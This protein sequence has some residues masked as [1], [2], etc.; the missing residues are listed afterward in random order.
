MGPA[1]E[2]AVIPYLD[3]KYA[4]TTR[5]WAFT[6]VKEIGGAASIPAL[7]AVQGPDTL[8]V[9]DVLHACR[10]RVPLGKEEWAR[11]LEDL[12][13]ADAKVRASAT[14]RI[15]VTPPVPERRAE[16]VG[17]LETLVN[18]Q[19]ADVRAAAFKGLVRW[20]GKDAVTLLARASTV[21]TPLARSPSS[22]PW[23]S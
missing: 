3:A 1:A 11:A 16:V 17:R 18:D 13:A 23:R 22:M 8:H 14:R 21:S 12:K 9:R 6:V 2:K 20:A 5:F 15:S 19:S 10:G 4:G 7:E